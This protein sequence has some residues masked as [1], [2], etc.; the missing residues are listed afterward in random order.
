MRILQQGNFYNH[1]ELIFKRLKFYEFSTSKFLFQSCKNPFQHL[2][3]F[4]EWKLKF[5]EKLNFFL[6]QVCFNPFY[7]SRH[8]ILSLGQVFKLSQTPIF[9]GRNFKKFFWNWYVL[10][11]FYLSQHDIFSFG[12]V[13]KL[14]QTPIF[15]TSKF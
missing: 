13:F 5:F 14:S 10:I 11:P 2:K 1:C 15:T 9:L 3:R 4:L 7:L 8:D 6:E 12:K